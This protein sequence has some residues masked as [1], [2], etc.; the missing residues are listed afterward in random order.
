M[1]AASDVGVVVVTYQSESTIVE[2]LERLLAAQDVQRIV[3]VDNASADGSADAIAAHPGRPRLVRL[4]T[5]I[6]F[7]RANN[8]AAQGAKGRL[9][10]LLNPDTIVQRR[11]I[12]LLVAFAR[13]NRDAGIWGGRTLFADGRLNPSS[14]WGRMTPWRLACRASGLAA[15]FKGSELFNGEA[16]GGWPRNRVREVDIVSGCFFLIDRALWQ[17]LGG[18]DPLF[19]M[20]GEEADLCLRAQALGARP[21]VTPAA[22]IV[23]YGGAS[24]RARAD[25]MVKLLAAKASL[26]E[27]HFAPAWRSAGLLLHAA[28]PLTRR[29]A[30]TLLARLSGK[31]AHA[32]A[33][34]TWRQI[35]DRRA[36]WQHGW[37]RRD[38]VSDALSDATA[39]SGVVT[40]FRNPAAG[41]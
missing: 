4:A 5:N 10:L 15:I 40:P 14:C 17:R 28:W 39:G 2:C 30:F 32:E 41:I 24:E 27:R 35:W 20:Y 7:A 8:L 31:P 19:F 34:A 21:V 13:A 12:D 23:H 9:L 1:S 29:I 25:K 16:Y 6:G 37:R 3:V 26:I 11:A 33:A 22:T 36:E 18:F 38:G